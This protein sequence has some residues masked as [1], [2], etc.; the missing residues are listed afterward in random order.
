[1]KQGKVWLVGAGPSDPG[2]LTIKGKSVLEKADAIVY[3]R[4]VSAGILAMAPFGAKLIDVGKNAGNHTLPQEEINAL[5]IRL[6]QEG[7]KWCASKEEILFCLGAAGK[8]LKRWPTPGFYMKLYRA[9][10]QQQQ[11]RHISEY[12]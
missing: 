9:L 11:F 10:R 1:M 5:L 4:L 3:D 7:K 12:R 6:A 2:L 8:K